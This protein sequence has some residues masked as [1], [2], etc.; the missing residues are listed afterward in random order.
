LG[1][2]LLNNCRRLT[3][4]THILCP[5]YQQDPPQAQEPVPSPERE[6]AQGQTAL[7]ALLSG[8]LVQVGRRLWQEQ[9]QVQ[10]PERVQAQVKAQVKA[11]VQQQAQQAV[12]SRSPGSNHPA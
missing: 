11:Q 3:V 1:L 10:E 6:Q 8:P 4:A 2:N 12:V 9:Q 7:P 5:K